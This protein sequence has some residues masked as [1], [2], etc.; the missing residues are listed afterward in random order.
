MIK[1]ALYGLTFV[2]CTFAVPALA[3]DSDL[4]APLATQTAPIKAPDAQTKPLIKKLL[5]ALDPI[6]N[7]NP[8]LT[9]TAPF[10]DK[11]VK[12]PS[13]I[14]AFGT[15]E[16]H[17]KSLSKLQENLYSS[18]K[19][20]PINLPH[21]STDDIKSWVVTHIS[22]SL[23]YTQ[24]SADELKNTLTLFTP[25]ARKQFTQFLKSSGMLN[26]LQTRQYSVNTIFEQP[27]L[28]IKEV[29]AEGRYKW[30]FE[31]NLLTTYIPFGVTDY[32]ATTARNDNNTLYI[33]IT[34]APESENPK[35]GL[36]I[37]IWQVK[38]N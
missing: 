6:D 16:E 37:E 30:L 20:I 26:V 33:Q 18:A 4:P 23:S 14:K 28:L 21:V 31:A 24:N 10:A 15:D 8:Y 1:L 9:L 3:Q 25:H 7:Y 13:D 32:R 38:T 22:H 11:D 17:M 2:T 29:S 34:R 35:D 19:A 36:L 27:P 12:P 5:P